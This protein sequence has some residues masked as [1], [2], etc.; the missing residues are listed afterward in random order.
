MQDLRPHADL[1]Y[2]LFLDGE[3]VISG[4]LTSLGNPLVSPDAFSISA[5]TPG[6]YTLTVTYDQYS[7]W[8]RPGTA[9]ATLGFD[10][11]RSDNDPPYLLSLNVLI[12]DRIVNTI[13]P[14]T[15]SGEVRFELGDELSEIDSASLEYRVDDEAWRG[16]SLNQSGPTG[17]LYTATLPALPPGSFVALRIRA[18]DEHGNWLVYEADPA[19]YVPTVVSMPVIKRDAAGGW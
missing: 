11:T 6:A 17:G 19:L 14:A 3:Q 18:D 15:R 13:S 1:P 5:T 2:E 16:L 7:V 4:T 8:T 12:G 10:T 9:T